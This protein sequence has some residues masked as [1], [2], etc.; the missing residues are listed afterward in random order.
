MIPR[1]N[2]QRV[3]KQL[4]DRNPVVAIL[5]ARQV[6][7]T[8]LAREFVKRQR[9]PVTIFDLERAADLA[10]L[11]DA[12]LGLRDLKGTVVLDEIQRRPELFTTLRVLVDRLRNPARFLV[13]GSASPALLHS[14]ESLAG[15]IAY[16]ELPGLTLDEVGVD[17]LNGLWL[18]GGFRRSFT[19]RSNSDS[20]AW[21]SDFVRTFL[22][23][24]V[25]QLGIRIP[26]RTL[27]RFWAMLAHYHGQASSCS[28]ELLILS[29]FC[30][31]QCES[32]PT[33]RRFQHGRPS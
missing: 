33:L 24:D 13:L 11:D 30:P 28:G 5:G 2:Q 10:R 19:A 32:P 14:S 6:G 15:R 18:R 23:R 1:R 17:H 21:R 25:A 12:E 4:L 3:L 20:R 16:H 27:E 26:S 22:E 9:R 7:K 8:P 29:R 31:S